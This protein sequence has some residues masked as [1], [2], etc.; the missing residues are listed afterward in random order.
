[1]MFIGDAFALARL[2]PEGFKEYRAKQKAKYQR[3]LDALKAFDFGVW[4]PAE[5][6]PGTHA[7]CFVYTENGSI[8]KSYGPCGYGGYWNNEYGNGG[9]SHYY[10]EPDPNGGKWPLEKS[11]ALIITHWQRWP[12]PPPPST[13]EAG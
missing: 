1:M 12:E 10:R 9:L 11:R 5:T 7:P 2:G 6:H 13:D 8:L 4:Y 3:E